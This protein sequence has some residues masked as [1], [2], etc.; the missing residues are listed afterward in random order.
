ML[1]FIAS[2]NTDDLLVHCSAELRAGD[3]FDLLCPASQSMGKLALEMKDVT[4]MDPVIVSGLIALQAAGM[5]VTIVN[6]SEA[7]CSALRTKDSEGL[8]EILWTEDATG[9]KL[10]QERSMNPSLACCE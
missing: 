5:D 8:F 1:R 6:P 3:E 10:S 4:R 7:V 9:Q 2:H